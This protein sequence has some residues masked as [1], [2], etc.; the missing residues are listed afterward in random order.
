MTPET[1]FGARPSHAIL[2]TEPVQALLNVKSEYLFTYKKKVSYK[3]TSENFKDIYFSPVQDFNIIQGAVKYIA[4]GH[5]ISEVSQSKQLNTLHKINKQNGLPQSTMYIGISSNLESI[6]LKDV[7]FYFD[8]LG[9][10]SDPIFFHHLKN[11]KWYVNEK[12]IKTSDGF[13][14]SNKTNT[15]KLESVFNDISS[16]TQ[17]IIQQVRNNY[18]KYYITVKEELK[19]AAYKKSSFEELDSVIAD[20][21]LKLDE[22]VRWI[23][24]VFP[25]VVTNSMLENVYCSLNAI[26]VINRRLNSFTYQMKEFIDIIPIKSESLFLDLKS[27]ENTSGKAYKLLSKNASGSEKGTFIVRSDNVG[28]LDHRNAKEYLKHLIEL[29]KDESASFSFFNNDFLYKNLSA[30]NQLISLL[31]NKVSEISSNA[32][33]TNYIS[34]KPFRKNETLLIDFWTTDG[35]E[36]NAIK[37]GSSLKTYSGVG[38]KQKS[39]VLLTTT[40]GGKND[41]SMNERLDAYRRSLLS[42]DRIVTKEDVKALCYELY[43]SKISDVKISNGYTTDV[44]LKKGLLQCINIELTPNNKVATEPNEWDA[45]NSNLLLH[46]ETHALNVFPYKVILKT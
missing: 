13:F 24:I 41:L 44:A 31:E 28:K 2:Y 29:L 42:R 17:N 25:R 19:K 32:T 27:I 3:N 46:L 45:L 14:N 39:S 4:T 8:V 10:D 20:N 9:V 18:L 11:A 37:S 33:E 6:S 21:K 30:L 26:P 7:S 22:N 36:G 1:V 40:F 35:T 23:K 16:K 38:I 5:S 12:E 15:L 34:L 43:S